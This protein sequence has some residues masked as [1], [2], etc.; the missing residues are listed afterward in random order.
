M[1]HRKRFKMAT[2]DRE[3]FI[4]WRAGRRKTAGTRRCESHSLRAYQK[5][6]DKQ[7]ATL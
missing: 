5:R 3:E 7:E 2:G 4:D 6:V 1:G